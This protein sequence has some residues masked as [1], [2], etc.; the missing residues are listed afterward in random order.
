M[1]AEGLG[2]PLRARGAA[3][4]PCCAMQAGKKCQG[5]RAGAGDWEH[6]AWDWQM[7]SQGFTLC[8]SMP[9][10]ISGPQKSL[11]QKVSAAGAFTGWSGKQGQMG[12]LD[13]FGVLSGGGVGG[14]VCFKQKI[15]QG[16]EHVAQPAA[17]CSALVC[18]LVPR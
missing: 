4:Q 11:G 15:P 9:P 16:H 8:L 17:A 12:H 14:C 3:H 10:S 5:S 7:Q 1:A 18:V 2:G 6:L 13:G